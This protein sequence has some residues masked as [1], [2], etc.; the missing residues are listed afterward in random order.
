MKKGMTYRE[1]REYLMPLARCATLP[2]YRAALMTALNALEVAGKIQ[3]KVEGRK[4][5]E[6]AQEEF[7]AGKSAGDGP[8]GLQSRYA[9]S[10]GGTQ[11]P[12]AG[13]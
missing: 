1:A 3:E 8:D 5:N 11:K 13:N 9:G 6:Q 2:G 10:H 4:S 12:W 7:S